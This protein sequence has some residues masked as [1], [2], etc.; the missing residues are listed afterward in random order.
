MGDIEER[1]YWDEYQ[2]VYQ[3]AIRETATEYAP[4]Y[5]VP[6]DNQWVSSGIVSQ[7]MSGNPASAKLQL[8]ETH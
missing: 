3:Q 6:A 8:P 7:L 2:E 4:W 1:Q 5:V